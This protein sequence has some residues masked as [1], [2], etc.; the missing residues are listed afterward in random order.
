MLSS[1]LQCG[2]L[3]PPS[4]PLPPNSA[5][6]NTGRKSDPVWGYQVIALQRNS[7]L[8]SDPDIVQ[9]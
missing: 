5:V 3:T 9:S 4:P 1:T 8:V 2:P 6:K 7:G